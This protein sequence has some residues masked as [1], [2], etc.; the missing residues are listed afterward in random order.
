MIIFE[1]V[2]TK[3]EMMSNIFKYTLEYD[4][5]IM[6]IQTQYK[7][8]DQVGSVDIGCGNE[9]GGGEADAG[10]DEEPAEKVIDVVYNAGLQEYHMDKK[11]FMSFLKAYFAKIVKYLEDNGKADRVPTFKKGATDFTKFIVKKY[12]E[13]ENIYVGKSH[14][15]DDDEIKGGIGITY[16]EDESAKGPVLYLFKDGLKEVKC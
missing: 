1:D 8:A 5:A 3:D 6:K 13:I 12:D 14:S 16:W 10:V 11:E 15:E 2:L 9:F 4:D 7:A